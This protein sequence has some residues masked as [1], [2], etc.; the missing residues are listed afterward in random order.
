M[1]RKAACHFYNKPGGCRKGSH[2]PFAHSGPS[3]DPPPS[4]ATSN[5]DTP[6]ASTPTNPRENNNISKD[7]PRGV[8]AFY[9]RTGECT[10]GFQCRYKHEQGSPENATAAMLGRSPTGLTIP[11]MLA[12]FL[13]SAALARLVEPGTDA[14]FTLNPKPRSPSE[15][16]NILKRFLIDGY[17][18]RTVYDMY[19]FA[20]L[21]TDATS[22]N[23]SWVSATSKCRIATHHDV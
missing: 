5:Q 8:C 20:G 19:A 22:H 9:W 21:L 13:N 10:R 17:S 6:S 3:G 15:V 14:L 2:C 1:S 12:P 7:I 23:T 18:F 16:H 11:A 4:G